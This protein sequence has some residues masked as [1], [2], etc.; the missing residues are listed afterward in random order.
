MMK[1]ALYTSVFVVCGGKES[2]RGYRRIFTLSQ[3]CWLMITSQGLGSS[4]PSTFSLGSS[5]LF[6][7]EPGK[8]TSILCLLLVDSQTSNNILSSFFPPFDLV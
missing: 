2:G 3:I 6:A 4:L 5:W 1:L 7:V 8:G